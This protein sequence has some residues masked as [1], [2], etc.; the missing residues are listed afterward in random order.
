MILSLLSHVMPTDS[1]Q[2]PPLMPHQ[3]LDLKDIVLP[4]PVSWWPPAPGW[5]LLLIAFALV[6]GLIVNYLKQRRLRRYAPR[7][8]ALNAMQQLAMRYAEDKNT[9]TLVRDV[10]AL[11]RRVAISVYPRAD[12]AGL[13]GE[14]WLAFLDSHAN[15]TVREKTFVDHGRVLIDAPYREKSIQDHEVQDLIALASDWI[16]A[17][18]EVRE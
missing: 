7:A 4:D 10:S 8:I 9:L 11:L 13:T 2:T 14:A 6:I 3:Q 16:D 18:R 17:Q 12:C 1:S 5:W 15:Q